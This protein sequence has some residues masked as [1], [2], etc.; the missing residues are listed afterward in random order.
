MGYFHSRNRNAIVNL[1]L[2]EGA[3]GADASIKL[4]SGKPFSSVQKL[5]PK[6]E[7]VDY[8]FSHWSLADG[9]EVVPAETEIVTGMTFY[10]VFVYNISTVSFNTDGG[11]DVAQQKVTKGQTWAYVKTL[12]TNPTKTGYN[13][14]HW[15][16][17]AGG[18]A[19]SDEFVFTADT[20]TIYAV[21]EI[22]K[23]RV[24]FNANGGNP[25]PPTQT[26]DY[27]T[28]WAQIKDSVQSPTKEGYT[29]LG[30]EVASQHFNF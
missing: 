17:S 9:G 15:S 16:D 5:L 2:P 6:P 14:I 1:V 8:K 23:V 11:T 4:P 3:S 29:F 28:T 30:W 25:T 24:T 10:A 20:V 21:Y 13:F 22:I 18:A 12:I 7:K 26:V 27:G 19:L